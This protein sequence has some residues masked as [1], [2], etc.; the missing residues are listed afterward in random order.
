MHIKN[1]CMKRLTILFGLFLCI[2]SYAQG[3]V[4]YLAKQPQKAGTPFVIPFENDETRTGLTPYTLKNS[5][6][7]TTADGTTYT[8]NNLR[9]KG[10]DE[11]SG[12]YNVIE[13]KCGSTTL[14]SLNYDDGFVYFFCE[15]KNLA[16]N[17][18][19][20]YQIDMGMGYTALVFTGVAMSSEPPYVTVVVLKDNTATLADNNRYY[21]E[22]VIRME[23]EDVTSLKMRKNTIEYDADDKPSEDP[24]IKYLTFMDGRIDLGSS[25][26]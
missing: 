8:V 19:S 16:N 6:T 1:N 7:V 21:L 9:Y 5:E 3:Q 20:F 15:N 25:P 10:W 4:V 23:E 18:K 11:E 14:L 13:I 17:H 2:S 26:Y 12:D 22:D 24:I